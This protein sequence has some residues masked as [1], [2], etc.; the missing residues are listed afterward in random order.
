[1][2]KIQYFIFGICIISLSVS[3][4]KAIEE[5]PKGFLNSKSLFNT[6]AG[7]NAGLIGVYERISTYY[8][9]GNQLPQMLSVGSGAFWT[10]V[11]ANQPLGKMAAQPTDA[12][13]KAV[14]RN[15]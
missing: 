1:M 3:C 13:G 9:M 10:S 5:D 11:A 4:K 15:V 14:D 7:A 12:G 6:A 2:K 8:Y